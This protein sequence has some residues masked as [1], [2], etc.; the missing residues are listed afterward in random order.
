MT[1]KKEFK[2]GF[3]TVKKVI[4]KGWGLYK[5]NRIENLNHPVTYKDLECAFVS[6]V[7]N[8]PIFTKILN[9]GTYSQYIIGL[10]NNY[11]VTTLDI[12]QRPNFLDTETILVGDAKQVNL[13]NNS[14]DAIIT[15]SSIEHFGLGRYGDEIDLVADLKSFK[16]FHRLLK[17]KGLL[18]FTVP[19]KHGFPEIVFN[20]NKIYNKEVIDSFKEGFEVLDEMYIS[21]SKLEFC[22]LE[23]IT[24]K[25]NTWDIYCGCWSVLK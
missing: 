5:L 20:A 23:N 15:L 1:T 19:I 25:T 16:E 11:N 18:I 4:P 12:R 2:K 14:F 21:K 13:P 6:S 22:N 17:P 7:L 3:K 9:V 24:K 10:M 8:L